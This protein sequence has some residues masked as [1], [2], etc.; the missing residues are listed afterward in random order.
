MKQLLHAT[1]WFQT[2]NFS[3]RPQYSSYNSSA[4]LPFLT[5]WIAEFSIILFVIVRWLFLDLRWCFHHSQKCE[6][7]NK[8]KGDHSV[9]HIPDC[10]RLSSY[11]LN[12]LRD[13]LMSTTS[14]SAACQLSYF[15]TAAFSTDSC[16]PCFFV[17]GI[18]FLKLLHLNHSSNGLAYPPVAP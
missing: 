16:C 13:V 4:V 5:N 15:E 2:S 8:H 3:E 9:Q 7:A 14:Y 10:S 17:G 6:E 11:R 12:S 1:R 18:L